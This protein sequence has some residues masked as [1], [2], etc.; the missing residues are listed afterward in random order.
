MFTLR[1]TVKGKVEL[2]ALMVALLPDLLK[3]LTIF[4][5][6]FGYRGR[7]ACNSS[8]YK[9]VARRE[10]FDYKITIFAFVVN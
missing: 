4:K 2:I 9:V 7:A 8:V 6:A 1:Q 5:A 10:A 3:S